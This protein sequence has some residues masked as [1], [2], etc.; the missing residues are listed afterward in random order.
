MLP[1]STVIIILVALAGPLALF[2]RYGAGWKEYPGVW[3]KLSPMI[4]FYD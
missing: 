3:M 1:T 2:I 4:L